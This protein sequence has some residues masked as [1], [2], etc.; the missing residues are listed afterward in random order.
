M[1]RIGRFRILRDLGRGGQGAVY[2]AEDEKLHR[3]AAIKVLPTGFDLTP[4]LLERFKREAEAASKLDHPGI[5]SVHET[6]ELNGLH[7]MTGNVSEWC[8]DW[9]SEYPSET[10]IDPIGTPKEKIMP[11][12]ILRGGS[13]LNFAGYG[14]S[15]HRDSKIPS[16]KSEGVGFRLVRTI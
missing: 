14:A 1:D 11:C 9:F 5:F 6:G 4:H 10:V 15:A 12:R 8:E 13:Y 16:Y 3:Q 7:Y 2:L